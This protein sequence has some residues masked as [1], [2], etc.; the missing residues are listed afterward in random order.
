ME[1][2]AAILKYKSNQ[3]QSSGKIKLHKGNTIL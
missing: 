2:E 3:L 1:Y